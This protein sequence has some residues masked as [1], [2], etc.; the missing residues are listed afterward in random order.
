VLRS[1]LCLF[2]TRA[3]FHHALSVASARFYARRARSEAL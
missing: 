3:S 2:G 1:I